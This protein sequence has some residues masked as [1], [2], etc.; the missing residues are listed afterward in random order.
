MIIQ[1]QEKK[2]CIW[3]DI[4]KQML[5]KIITYF[6]ILAVVA[7][8][9]ATVVPLPSSRGVKIAQAAEP[10]KAT[11]DKEIT[12]PCGW[13]FGIISGSFP[14]C[15]LYT[16]VFLL[17]E[18]GLNFSVWLAGLASGLFNVSI[19][20]SLTGT[21]FDA[22]KNIMIKDGWTMVRDL[23]NLVFIFI[24]LYAAIATIL[25]YGNMDIKKILPGLIV[26]ALLV[27]FSLMIS[28]VVIDASHV[29]AWEF[30]NQIDSTKKGTVPDMRDSVEIAGNFTK[31]NLANVFLAGFNPQRLLIEG[32]N[33]EDKIMTKEQIAEEERGLSAEELAEKRKK[34]EVLK[35]QELAMTN[36]STWKSL[37]QQANME[38]QGMMST[39][40]RMALIITLE[41]VLAFFASFI[42]LVGAIMFIIRVVVLWLI[43]I[44][45]PI[46]FLG[47]ILPSMKSYSTM[48][49][50][51]LIDQSFF[52][53]AFLFM[54][55]LATKFVNSNLIDSLL[56][57]TPNDDSMIILGLN[58]GTILSIFFNFLVVGVLLSACLIVAKK[59]GGKSAEY[60]MKWAHKG[61]D[62][63][64]GGANKMLWKPSRYGLRYGAG[65][66]GD[67]N[68]WKQ[69]FGRIPGGGI[70]GRKFGAMRKADEDKTRKEAEKYA[71]TLSSA[72][73][74]SLDKDKERGFVG[75]ALYGGGFFEKTREGYEKVIAKKRADKYEEEKYRDNL[76]ILARISDGKDSKGKVI[77][78]EAVVNSM[79]N[80]GEEEKLDKEIEKNTKRIA[81]AYKKA[82]EG[83]E[84]KTAKITVDLAEQNSRLYKAIEDGS[85]V[86]NIKKE[87]IRLEKEK[88]KLSGH[89]MI[90]AKKEKEREDLKKSIDKYKAKQQN[91]NLGSKIG[92]VAGGGAGG[93]G[94]KKP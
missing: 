51:N 75:R 5:K 9:F 29:F 59:M 7:P 68:W 48:W 11:G 62:L 27:N 1:K 15:I 24:L 67:S 56:K 77:K 87:I 84:D 71:G 45:S 80:R 73:R 37:M 92:S 8:I 70:L 41:I 58:M 28:K 49:W 2:F 14:E 31:K 76:A 16:G 65:A 91:E 12:I 69:S 42:L 4:K 57:V 44:F 10:L 40:W 35:N 86:D 94:S 82:V 90:V 61:K 78:R 55:M 26:A 89:K 64:L 17:Y 53:P 85:P 25:Q 52:A 38:G 20:F 79:L 81:D 13:S 88:S 21:S 83:I 36:D 32:S 66:A 60:G 39:L 23:F 6:L 50:K 54:F 47:M 30:Y 3:A 33:I 19:Q 22:E 34:E 18:I 93:G 43:M 74:I 63:A 72:G 46:A